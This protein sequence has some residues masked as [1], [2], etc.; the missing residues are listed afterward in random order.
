M[1]GGDRNEE[2]SELKL[3]CLSWHGSQ[4]GYSEGSDSVN[5][6]PGLDFARLDLR[7]PLGLGSIRLALPLGRA[8]LG[9]A[10][11]GIGVS[12]PPQ[13]QCTLDVGHQNGTISIRFSWLSI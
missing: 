4:G 7:L 10:G 12:E 11:P 6:R 13:V 2:K 5:A 9:C 1:A 3:G 8:N